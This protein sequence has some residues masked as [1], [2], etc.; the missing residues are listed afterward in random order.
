MSDV[1]KKKKKKSKQLDHY[2]RNVIQKVP[3]QIESF[4]ESDEPSMTY[5]TGSWATDV[6][7]NFT[8]KQ[9]EKIFTRMKKYQDKCYFTQKKLPFQTEYENDKGELV[10]LQGYEYQVRRV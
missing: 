6:L 9:S 7:N 1:K 5:Y 3:E 2:L 10:S 4:L 8:E